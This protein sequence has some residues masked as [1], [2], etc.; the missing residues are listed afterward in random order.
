MDKLQSI[1]DDNLRKNAKALYYKD[2]LFKKYVDENM[3]DIEVV[4]G[5][6]QSQQ[7]ADCYCYID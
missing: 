2:T 6:L 7:G 1:Q 5:F 4:E 3:L